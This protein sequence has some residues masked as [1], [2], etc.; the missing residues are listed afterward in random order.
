MIKKFDLRI[1]WGGLLI[2]A[3]CLFLLQEMNLIPSAWDFVW[4]VV[5]A[6]AGL[7][8]LVTFFRDR[9]QWWPLIPGLGLL[10]LGL[11]IFIDEFFP[12]AD[13]TGAIF[14]GSI[15]IAFWVVYFMNRENWWAVIPAGVLTTLTFV[16]I[17]EPY[18]Q[19]DADGGIFMVG[20]GLT[21]LLL[22]VLP[23]SHGRMLWAFI[24]GSIVSI[25]G[26]LLLSN[27]IEVFEFIWPIALI[28]LGGYFILR[29]F[30]KS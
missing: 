19:G 29:F 13:W 18:L 3:G 9:S 4:S 10:A 27:T 6:V 7:M 5:F 24:P 21:F 22:G 17:L 11:L 2:L 16:V 15:G 20:L 28:L 30:R 1:L 14:L 25:I 8:F 23:T 12:G 26:L